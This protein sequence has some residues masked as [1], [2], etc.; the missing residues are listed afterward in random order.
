MKTYTIEEAK[1]M[2]ADSIRVYLKKDEAGNYFMREAAVLPTETVS[3]HGFRHHTAT[4]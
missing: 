4:G 1:K 3:L 2:T